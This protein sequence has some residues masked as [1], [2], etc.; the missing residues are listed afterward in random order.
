M[1]SSFLTSLEHRRQRFHC[2]VEAV[3]RF[4]RA[5]LR[6][7]ETEFLLDDLNGD[8]VKC[9][10]HGRDLGEQLVCTAPLLDHALYG[11]HMTLGTTQGIDEQAGFLV[12]E[13]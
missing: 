9:G 11:A 5:A 1:T 10:F 4:G 2:C 7:T 3:I 13:V 6:Q 12:I 8:P